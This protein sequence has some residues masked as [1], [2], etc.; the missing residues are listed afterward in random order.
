MVL[1][2]KMTK[3][4]FYE[5]DGK[6]DEAEIDLPS[7]IDKINWDEEAIKHLITSTTGFTNEVQIENIKG[8]Y[9]FGRIIRAKEK[10]NY[11]EKD[12]GEEPSD[13]D[14][15]AELIGEKTRDIVNFVFT[16]KEKG[17]ILL[18]ETGF[19]TGGIGFVKRFFEE[20]LSPQH[21]E[22]AY[23]PMTSNRIQAIS[24][25]L[26]K[27]LKR[28][29]I[30]FRKDAEIPKSCKQAEDTLKKVMSIEDYSVKVEASVVRVTDK[31]WR[32]IPVLSKVYRNLFGNDLE[33]AIK[34][35]IDFPSFLTNFEVDVIDDSKQTIHED[36]LERYERKEIR[37]NK[38]KLD[39]D[40]IK[41]EL[42]QAL[43]EK[44]NQEFNE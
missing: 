18:V 17:L 38:S 9:Y 29:V 10:E 5:M 1:P 4:Y 6:I 7:L 43:A 34:S 14:S 13:L 32:N 15:N 26:S 25:I 40:E 31:S 44:I 39:E 3:F 22:I 37:L 28:I 12:R 42:C 36:V 23:K 19:Q 11:F 20:I 27:K 41:I 16:K 30:Q 33:E 21:V 35:G 8:D 2:E 24:S